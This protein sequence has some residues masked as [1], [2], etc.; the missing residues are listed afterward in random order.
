MSRGRQELKETKASSARNLTSGQARRAV[1]VRRRQRPE[2][3]AAVAE[4]ARYE[5]GCRRPQH[6]TRRRHRLERGVA[7]A[8]AARYKDGGRRPQLGTR[9]T[10]GTSQTS[11]AIRARRSRRGSVR[12]RLPSTKAP[13][14]VV[15]NQ[16]YTQEFMQRNAISVVGS[17]RVQFDRQN[18]PYFTQQFLKS[19]CTVNW[20][21][22]V[23]WSRGRVTHHVL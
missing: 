22:R 10:H 13:T 17:Q 6:G 2:R 11:T 14:I 3:G 12:E 23:A 15:R 18:T 7:V 1:P 5:D 21:T 9:V 19:F 20:T 8:E 4:A 16:P